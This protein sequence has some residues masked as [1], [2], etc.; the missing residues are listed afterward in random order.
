[1][2]LFQ[3]KI[4][5]DD[6]E[7]KQ[8]VA[9]MLLIYPKNFRTFCYFYVMWPHTAAYLLHAVLLDPYGTQYESSDRPECWA[10][11]CDR[12]GG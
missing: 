7:K 2:H 3:L 10:G 11:V 8:C 1:M 6:T 9:Y 12:H 5:S 4:K